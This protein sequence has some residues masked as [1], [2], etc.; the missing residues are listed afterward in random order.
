MTRVTYRSLHQPVYCEPRALTIDFPFLA[1][2]EAGDCCEERTAHRVAEPLRLFGG[3][4]EP[5]GLRGREIGPVSLHD[6]SLR[7]YRTS[8]NGEA[9]Y[10]GSS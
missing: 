2:R 3:T 1:E 4:P 6:F 10:M 9:I 7:Y 5:A 8:G